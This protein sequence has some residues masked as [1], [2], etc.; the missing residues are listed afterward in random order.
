MDL[1]KLQERI[2]ELKK[3]RGYN[4]K[5]IYLEFCYLQEEASEAF[6]AYHKKKPDLDLELADVAIYL[7]GLSEILGIDLEQAILRKFHINS[8]RKYELIDG[9]HVRTQEADANLSPEEI[10]SKYNLN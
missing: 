2:Y 7:F 9:V 1:K 3:E 6:N 8:N 4:L 10:K 5:D